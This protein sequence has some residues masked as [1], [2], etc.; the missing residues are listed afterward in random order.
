MTGATSIA[1]ALVLGVQSQ[2]PD[3]RQLLVLPAP[4]QQ[5]ALSLETTLSRRRSVRDYTSATLTAAELSQL[6]WAAQGVTSPAGQR[7]APSAGALY[8]LEIYVAISMGLYH[9]EPSGHRLVAVSKQ[10]ARSALSAAAHG[11][12]AVARAPAV[13]IIAAVP[14]RTAV[15]YGDRATRYVLLEAGHA[16]QNLLLQGVALGLGA[17]PVG[18]F[19]DVAVSRALR[20]PPGE[21]PL[22]LIPIG[23]G[24]R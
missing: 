11:Q 10:D 5:G 23:H 22:Y 17:V 1:T 19:E 12:E 14:A 4:V 2:A 3:S 7:T 13:F 20:L 18:A 15:R 16:C 24:R 8:P 9:Y 6:L 21:I